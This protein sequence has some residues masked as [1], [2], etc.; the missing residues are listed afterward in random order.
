[1][2]K[3]LVDLKRIEKIRNLYTIGRGKEGTCYLLED[4]NEIIKLFH[5]LDQKRKIYFDDLTSSNISFPKDILMYDDLVAG[6][7]MNYLDGQKIIDGFP[8]KI[9]LNTLKQMY[10]DIK[11]IIID[12]PDLCMDDM[13][14]A[15]ILI[16]VKNKKI[17]LIDTSRWY[18]KE[19]SK[20]NNIKW[21][22]MILVYVLC[23]KNME[24]LG[25]YQNKSPELFGLYRSYK[26]GYHVPFLEILEAIEDEIEEKFSKNIKIIDDLVPKVYKKS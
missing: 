20:D 7:T 22:D 11:N 3:I 26:L 4:T 25:S 23:R 16:D 13:C 8:K 2:G 12:Y 1:M 17:N 15:N 6:Y 5:I 14:L 10:I 19:K 24:W 9:E 21:L 18:P